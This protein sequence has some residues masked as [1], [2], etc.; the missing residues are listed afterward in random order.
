MKPIQEKKVTHKRLDEPRNANVEEVANNFPE[1]QLVSNAPSSN[2]KELEPSKQGRRVVKP[3]VEQVSVA[4][5]IKKALKVAQ[6]I[7][8]GPNKVQK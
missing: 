6:G 3:V 8:K 1:E 5:T 7:E 4:K 2:I